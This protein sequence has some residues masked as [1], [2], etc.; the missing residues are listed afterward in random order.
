MNFKLALATIDSFAN[1][2]RR[3][4]TTWGREAQL[5]VIPL[6]FGGSLFLLLTG[7]AWGRGL[8]FLTLV[9]L[10]SFGTYTFWPMV[11]YMLKEK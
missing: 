7:A 8:M 9:G 3:E 11:Q 6:G 4:I 5:V 1:S 2:L 10:G